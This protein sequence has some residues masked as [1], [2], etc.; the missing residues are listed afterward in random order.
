[1]ISA[2]EAPSVGGVGAI[3]NATAKTAQPI[4]PAMPPAMLAFRVG[5]MPSPCVGRAVARHFKSN[6]TLI[7]GLIEAADGSAAHI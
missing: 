1:V 5:P 3:A 2:A 4:M 6:F 7:A